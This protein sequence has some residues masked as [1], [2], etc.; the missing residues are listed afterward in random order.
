M[1]DNY[2]SDVPGKTRY[3]LRITVS[4]TMVGTPY[5]LVR[6]LWF[7]TLNEAK[8][9]GVKFRLCI[10]DYTLW[11]PTIREYNDTQ[12]FSFNSEEYL[13]GIDNPIYI[14]RVIE[15]PADVISALG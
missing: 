4:W 3:F 8:E 12:H 6:R 15:A 13:V 1:T 5:T 11:Q 14:Q 10:Y 2:Q 9:W 7:D